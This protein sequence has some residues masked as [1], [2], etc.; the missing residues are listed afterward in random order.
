VK[1]IPTAP[2]KNLV[3]LR[4][5]AQ[6]MEAQRKAELVLGVL[7]KHGVI[8]TADTANFLDEATRTLLE[9]NFWEGVK[10]GAKAHSSN[11]KAIELSG[12][13]QEKLF[14]WLDKNL[15][16]YKNLDRVAEAAQLN[17]VV[18]WGVHQI[19]RKITEYRKQRV[20]H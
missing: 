1:K 18:P 11:E 4:G 10:A 2:E 6:R 17:S 9:D 5:L 14:A 7:V 13:R 19:R 12:Q 3:G 16:K 20:N 8:T 15:A